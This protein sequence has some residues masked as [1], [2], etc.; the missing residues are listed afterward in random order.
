[1]GEQPKATSGADAQATPMD[2]TEAEGIAGGVGG[3]ADTNPDGSFESTLPEG[4]T[5]IKGPGA[6]E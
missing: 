1:M 2:D 3:D 4:G 6:G 5:I